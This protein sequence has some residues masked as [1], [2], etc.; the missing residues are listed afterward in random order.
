MPDQEHFKG[1]KSLRSR[2][3]EATLVKLNKISKSI[4]NNLALVRIGHQ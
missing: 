1:S 2:E 4:A 3:P